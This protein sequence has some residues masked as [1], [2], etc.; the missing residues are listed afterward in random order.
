MRV[1]TQA[2][3]AVRLTAQQQIKPTDAVPRT[4]TESIEKWDGMV[5]FFV[6]K[7]VAI[8]G[9]SSLQLRTH[10]ENLLKAEGDPVRW[11]ITKVDN[12]QGTCAVDAVL[13]TCDPLASLR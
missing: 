5:L 1:S 11:A 4:T 2:Q 9:R 3:P 8:D 6:S 13:S 10:I 12:M 7:T